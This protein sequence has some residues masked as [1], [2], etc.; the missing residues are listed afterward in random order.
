MTFNH[1]ASVLAPQ[2]VERMKYIKPGGS[3]RDIPITFC[4]RACIVAENQT[5]QNDMG[6]SVTMG[7]LGRCLP[8]V[9]LTGELSSFPIRTVP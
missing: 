6:V 9:T 1:F 2:N 5:I 8:N 4:L 3:W 7:S